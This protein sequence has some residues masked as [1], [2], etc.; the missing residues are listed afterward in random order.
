MIKFNTCGLKKIFGILVLSLLLSWNTFA[1]ETVP[2]PE[3][4]T[5][6]FLLNNGWRLYS[7]NAVAFSGS[8]GRGETG[9]Y[10]NLIKGRKIITCASSSGKVF[11]NK[12]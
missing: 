2:M 8:D 11:C 1:A 12:P 9:I 6:N 5:V 7:T 4:T 3:N 10:Y